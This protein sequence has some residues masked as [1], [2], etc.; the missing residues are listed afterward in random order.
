VTETK[1][2]ATRD[3]WMAAKNG[4][5]NIS[6][7]SGTHASDAPTEMAATATMLAASLVI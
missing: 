5:R 6:A 7:I 2:A 1:Y 3:R 4:I